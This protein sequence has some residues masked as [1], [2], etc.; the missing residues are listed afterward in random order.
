MNKEI[1]ELYRDLLIAYCEENKITRELLNNFYEYKLQYKKLQE[2]IDKAI[3]Y[4]KKSQEDLEEWH[5]DGLD[6]QLDICIN[7]LKG[8]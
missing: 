6:P 1:E 8:E 2:R 5:Y 4:L 7:I 3:E